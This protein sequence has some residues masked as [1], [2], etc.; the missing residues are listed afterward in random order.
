MD[1]PPTLRAAIDA[2][3]EGVAAADLGRAARSLSDRYRGEVRDGR[4]HLGSR[5]AALAYLAARMPATYAAV[6]SAMAAA[7]AADDLF[8]PE[9]MLDVGAGPGTALWAAREAW[10]SLR[11]ATLVEASA[12]IREAGARLTADAGVSV[13]WVAGDAA[14]ALPEGA[15]DLVTCAYVLNEIAPEH[16]AGLVETLWARAAG[17][18]LLV[19][20][21]TPAGW[22]RI[23]DA[24]AVLI[25][26]EAHVL[27][28]CP[29]E[30]ACPLSPPD[31]C[32]FSVRL[33]RSRLH[34][35]AK[36]G[37]IGW[38]DEPFI[39]LVAARRQPPEASRVLTPPRA[40]K[41]KVELK[42]CRPDG[43]LQY[44]LVTRREGDAFRLARRAD[45]GE[46]VALPQ[47]PSS[48]GLEN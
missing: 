20:P 18:L 48:R 1:L 13:T 23:L 4:A 17:Q 43:R 45:W 31:W 11:H 28:P 9:S 47:A 32:H 12:T 41:G 38:E 8:A 26:A 37:E 44:R 42:L 6:H 21:G 3:L 16:R 30:Q 7:V 25:A 40:G 46:A 27:A 10:P 24:R 14:A 15:H 5:E 34:R 19:E 22:R 36:G 29:H 39:Y 2:E 35:L 33:A